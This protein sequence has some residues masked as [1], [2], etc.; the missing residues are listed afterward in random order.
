MNPLGSVLDAA[1]RGWLL[2]LIA[3]A[4][5]CFL[6]KRSA[7]SRHLLWTAA[8]TGQLLLLVFLHFPVQKRLA[9]S[10]PTLSLPSAGGFYTL[11][12]PAASKQ[13]T[14]KTSPSQ[15]VRSIV[16]IPRHLIWIVLTAIWTFGISLCLARAG[17][18]TIRLRRQALNARPIADQAWR[19]ALDRAANE[20][21]ITRPI[22]LLVGGKF[23]VPITWGTLRPIVL[24]PP[25]VFTWTPERRRIV[26]LHELAHVR[27]WDTLTQMIG[28]LASAIFW[29]SP[30]VWLAASRMRS[31]RERACDEMVVHAG[32]APSTYAQQLLDMLRSLNGSVEPAYGALAAV[33][34]R[35]IDARMRALLRPGP[36][37]SAAGATGSWLLVAWSLPVSLS[38]A[39]V[40]PVA[41]GSS[42]LAANGVTSCT[43]REDGVLDVTLGSPGAGR[44]ANVGAE[45]GGR[46]VLGV[47]DGKECLAAVIVGP[48]SLSSDLSDIRTLAPGGSVSVADLR[49]VAS[50]RVEF[51]DRNGSILRRYRS[52]GVEHPWPEGQRWFANAL[53][54]VVRDNGYDA[55]VRVKMLLAQGGADSV[56]EE[57]QRSRTDP[58][59]RKLLTALIDQIALAAS[60]RE[61]VIRMANSLRSSSDR[62]AVLGRL[63]RQRG[64]R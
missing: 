44:V 28:Q 19:D 15:P 3:G 38:L 53:A 58:G 60:D 4:L 40:H 16:P 45:S 57:A 22:T 32:V 35:E 59:K 49:S 31:D 12:L 47:F 42:P 24:L 8:M 10:V 50:P 27:R 55:G 61:R 33:T 64:P 63:A 13:A 7:A 37:P 52:G 14:S 54:R 41:G 43:I 21:A 6:R 23:S 62:E 2:F 36:R 17:I 51:S 39:L 18:G 46:T 30:L 34:G 1:G 9:L 11:D 20:L 56:L 26:L 5:A 25:D 29:F 48:V